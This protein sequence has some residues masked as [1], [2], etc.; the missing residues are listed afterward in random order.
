M[1]TGAE[2]GPNGA[3]IVAPPP[4]IRVGGLS[5]VTRMVGMAQA[6]VVRPEAVTQGGT[7]R[8]AAEARARVEL[9]AATTPGRRRRTAKIAPANKCRDLKEVRK[10]R[11]GGGLTIA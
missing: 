4:D 5:T 1:D 7:Q 2:M 3:G 10:A 9:W 6:P 8:E 11:K